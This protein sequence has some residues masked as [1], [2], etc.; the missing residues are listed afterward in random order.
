MAKQSIVKNDPWLESFSDIIQN[1][2]SAINEKINEL[3]QDGN[4][5]SFANGHLYYGLHKSSKDWIFR[6]WAP[7]AERLY[8][9][10]EFK[11]HKRLFSL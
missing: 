6:E 5:Q 2:N 4:L 8:L 7:N 11:K 3:S 9:I 10:G 1:R